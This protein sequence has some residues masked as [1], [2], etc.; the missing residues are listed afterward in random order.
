MYIAEAVRSPYLCSTISGLH[1]HVSLNRNNDHL[2][3]ILLIKA[4]LL[5]FPRRASH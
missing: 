2:I 3:Y 5:V 4:G 1:C